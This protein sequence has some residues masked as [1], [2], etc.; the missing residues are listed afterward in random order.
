MLAIGNIR[1]AAS[2]RWCAFWAYQRETDF[3]MRI[4]TIFQTPTILGRF[5]DSVWD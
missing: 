4:A 2:P 3:K 1:G 5:P